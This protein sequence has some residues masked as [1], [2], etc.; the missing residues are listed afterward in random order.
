MTLESGRVNRLSTG[1]GGAHEVSLA[2]PVHVQQTK[3]YV[4]AYKHQRVAVLSF[5]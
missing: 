4:A 1:S 2:G 3:R 5:F